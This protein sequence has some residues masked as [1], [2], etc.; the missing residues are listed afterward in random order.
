MIYNGLSY[1][2][3]DLFGSPYSNFV[4]SATVE[5]VG[6]IIGQMV[7]DRYGR[8][9]PYALSLTCSGLALLSFLFIPKGKKYILYYII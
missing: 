6:T 7:Y 8:K 1:S 5:L 3:S 4:I 9:I 2:T